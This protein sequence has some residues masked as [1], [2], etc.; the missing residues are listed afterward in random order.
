MAI[1]PKAT[2][3]HSVTALAVKTAG[4]VTSRTAEST[5]PP[6]VAGPAVTSTA[7]QNSDWEKSKLVG[8]TTW[9]SEPSRPPAMA[10][11]KAVRQKTMTREAVGSTPTLSVAVGESARARSSRPRR[12][13]RTISMARIPATTTARTK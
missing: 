1:T 12:V 5:A 9:V 4:T 2:G 13:T 6:R 11:R 8:L 10:A 7:I 3:C